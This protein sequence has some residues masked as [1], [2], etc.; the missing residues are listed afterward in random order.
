MQNQFP[1]HRTDC[2][3]GGPA[4]APCGAKSADINRIVTV[5]D[6]GSA[7]A[8]LRKK[9]AADTPVAGFFDGPPCAGDNRKLAARDRELDGF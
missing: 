4:D 1:S 6:R 5:R 8:A 7:P 2:R 3:N 9:E